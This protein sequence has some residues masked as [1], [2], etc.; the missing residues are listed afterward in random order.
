[1]ENSH[2]HQCLSSRFY[3]AF[4]AGPAD[5]DTSGGET[6]GDTELEDEDE[7]SAPGIS[8]N[9]QVIS[10]SYSVSKEK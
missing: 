8:Q 1:M 3:T 4:S 10:W 9:P 7:D 6:D 2:K 5:V